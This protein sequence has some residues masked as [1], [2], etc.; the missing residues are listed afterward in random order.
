M[1]VSRHIFIHD[2]QLIDEF[3]AHH[4]LP[5][6]DNEWPG[7]YFFIRYWDGGPHIRLRYKWEE[8]RKGIDE[9]LFEMLSE[10]CAEYEDWHFAPIDHDERVS[11]TEGGGAGIFY[12]NFSIQDIDYHP[13]LVRYGGNT[14]MGASE[15]IFVAST[16]LASTVIQKI[17]RNKR[18]AIS[19]DLM[20]ECGKLARKL[21]I[22]DSVEDFFKD[23]NLVWKH[24]S[25][26]PEY[27]G[28]TDY[29]KQRTEK[30]EMN[31]VVEAYKPY[32]SF[33]GEK[34]R[35]IIY[36]QESYDKQ[37]VY[38]ILISHIHMFNNRLGVSPEREYYFSKVLHEYH[39]RLSVPTVKQG[40]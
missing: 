40:G 14:A 23:Y 28:L 12:P 38:Y 26:Q 32:L 6:M 22:I 30:R 13:E 15:D 34:M 9:E 27:P 21:G 2:Y 5:F 3:L 35:M 4:L 39:Q 8:S 25:D 7:E 10:F 16:Q 31:G 24:F 1:W 11:K 29:L 17:S 19:F 33:L 37:N 18:Y 36:H 20:Y